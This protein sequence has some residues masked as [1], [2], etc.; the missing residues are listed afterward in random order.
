[1]SVL[2]DTSFLLAFA[3]RRDANHAR[4][5][6]LMNELRTE[7]RVVPAPVLVELFYM[8]MIRVSYSH[9]LRLFSSTRTACHIEALNDADMDRMQQIMNTYA[10]AEFDFTDVAL[11]AGGER[12]GITRVCTFDRRDFS[13]FRP[14]HCPAYELLP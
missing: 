4:A 6:E 9:A 5:A 10:D 14:A 8:T 12:L 3:F 2:L 11:M 7:L 13:I 1:M